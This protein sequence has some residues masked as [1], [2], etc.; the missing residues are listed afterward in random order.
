MVIKFHLIKGHW[1]DNERR[2][3]LGNELPPELIRASIHSKSD[4]R[5]LQ[6]YACGATVRRCPAIAAAVAFQMLSFIQI[7]PVFGNQIK[8]TPFV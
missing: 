3:F 4:L 2:A 6:L 1:T 5:I 7:V 8:S